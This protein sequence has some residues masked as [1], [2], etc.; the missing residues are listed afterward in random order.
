MSNGFNKKFLKGQE[1][2]LPTVNG[3][4]PLI[5]EHL[6]LPYTHFEILYCPGRKAP[7]YS[8]VNIDGDGFVEIV[9]GPDKWVYED[10]ISHSLQIGDDF[11][12]LTKQ[13]FHRGHIVRRIDPCW[14][15]DAA[16]AVEDTFHYT[17]ACP[18]HYKFNPA[19]WLE[20]ER[21]ILEKGAVK[22][23]ANLSVFAGPVISDM[24]KPFIKHVNGDRIFIP[25]RFWKV[26]YWNKADGRRAAV[27]F[28]QSQE[29][30]IGEYLDHG[31]REEKVSRD[32]DLHL[33]NL[34]FKGNAV[35]QVALTTIEAVTGL[36]F[37]LDNV[38]LP[39]VPDKMRELKNEMPRGAVA[40]RSLTS[41]MGPVVISGLILD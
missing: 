40:Y 1:L 14:G 28:M 18:Q 20:L 30:L 24:D 21:N 6:R 33:E 39:Q 35:Y 19:I 25:S 4:N 5:E 12:T 41:T 37:D 26:V 9:R 23:D 16:L 8:A 2:Q 11:Y 27:G 34:K 22:W 31:F 32:I 15:H 17:N 10:E 38:F 13:A 29:S 36:K 7:V 3:H